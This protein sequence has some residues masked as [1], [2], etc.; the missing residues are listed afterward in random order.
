[1]RFGAFNVTRLGRT[2]WHVTVWDTGAMVVW[3]TTSRKA[4]IALARTLRAAQLDCD[5]CR[6]RSDMSAPVRDEGNRLVAAWIARW[7]LNRVGTTF[8]AKFI[9]QKRRGPRKA[10][11]AVARGRR[12]GQ[13]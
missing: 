4:A 12:T 8:S 6:V 7:R 11:G 3:P 13:A 2:D 5:G 1:M 9:P 10:V